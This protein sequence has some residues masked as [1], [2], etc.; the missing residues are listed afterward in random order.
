MR[1]YSTPAT[2]SVPVRGSLTDDVV[3]HAQSRP[4]TV[5]FRRRD[6]AADRGAWRDVTA[7]RFHADVVGVAKGLLATGLQLGDRLG[8]LCGTRYEWTVADYAAWWVG[9]V[10][11]PL[12]DTAPADQVRWVLADSAA[13]G[14]LLETGT[15]RLRVESVGD[16][17]PS[18][19][20]V[21]TIEDGGLEGLRARGADVTDDD[22]ERRRAEVSPDSLATIIY[23]SGTTG[24]PKGCCLTHGNFMAELASTTDALPELFDPPDASTLLFLPL[25]HVFARVVQVGCVHSGTTLGHTADVA[26]LA[27][28]MAEFR[29]TFVLAVPRIFEKVY[30]ASSQQAAVTGRGRVFGAAAAT[31]IAWSRASDGPGPGFALRARH[32]A[33]ERLVYRRL[34]EGLGGRLRHAVSGGAP[35]GDRL[36]HF[37]RG[38]GVTVLEGYGSTETTAALTVNLPAEQKVGTVGRPLPG[39][40]VRVADDGELLFRGPQVFDGYWHDDRATARALADGWFHSGDLGEID[41]EGFVRVTGRREELLVTAGG[42]HVAPTVLEDRVRTHPLVSQCLVVGDGR[43]YVGAL[44]TL[45]RDATVAWARSAG[46]VGEPADLV[47]DPALRAELQ[48]AVDSVNT[49]VSAA[50]SIRRFRVLP[51]D[52]TEAGGHVTPSLKLKRSLVVHDFRADIESLY[53]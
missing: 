45:D 41:G 1:K 27:V 53:A 42:K 17:L 16:A 44:I 18:L 52:W 28:R 26:D 11:V 4:D 35:L 2:F 46:R 31:A 37:F 22:L 15:H 40:A 20:H 19:Q 3:E 47:D 32:A 8:L 23:T 10:T 13:V 6:P 30:T 34:R 38:I 12:Y 5:L 36:G 7:S 21:W 49:T 14:C 9:A 43:P 50:E 39:V 25:A 51:E 48:A 24:R 33:F 29:P